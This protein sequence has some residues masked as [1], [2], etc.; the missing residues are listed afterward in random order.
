MNVSEGESCEEIG[1]PK[2]FIRMK[3][4]GTVCQTCGEETQP[5]DQVW[6]KCQT[7]GCLGHLCCPKCGGVI[8]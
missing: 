5:R 2:G 4:E 6:E 7:E 3:P 8:W 1:G